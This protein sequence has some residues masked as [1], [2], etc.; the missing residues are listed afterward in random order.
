MALI[1]LV[2]ISSSFLS[3][4]VATQFQQA[5]L[6]RD[7]KRQGVLNG[8]FKADLNHQLSVT[9]V[10]SSLVDDS[11]DCTFKCVNEPK[12]KSFNFAAN[13]DS[14]GLYPCE[15][16]ET[17]KYRSA[18]NNFQAN[19]AFHHFSPWVSIVFLSIHS[20]SSLPFKGFSVCIL[21]CYFTVL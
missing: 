20:N 16:L 19:A 3:Q 21:P 13:P 11:L 6:Y 10:S 1:V 18:E 4:T 12:C 17:D 14:N 5:A 9:K 2:L 15:L 7:Q 8:N